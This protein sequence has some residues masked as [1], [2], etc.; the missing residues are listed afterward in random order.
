MHDGRLL[1]MQIANCI[2]NRSYHLRHFRPAKSQ[3]WLVLPQCLQVWSLHVVHHNADPAAFVIVEYM[4]NTR[5]GRV[6][7]LPEQDVVKGKCIPLLLAEAY[8]LFEREHILSWSPGALIFYQ[9]D[10]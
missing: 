6:M 8:D 5:Q 7:N 3:L 1:L 10:R 9:V 4:I 2:N